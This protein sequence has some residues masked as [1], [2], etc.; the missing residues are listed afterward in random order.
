MSRRQRSS[1]VIL[2]GTP[3][4]AA[5]GIEMSNGQRWLVVAS[6]VSQGNGG[7]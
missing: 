1:G 7:V 4:A 5:S 6:L 3:S 2:D